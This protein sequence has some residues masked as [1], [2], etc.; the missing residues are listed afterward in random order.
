MKMRSRLT[1]CAAAVLL[2]VSSARGQLSIT[3]LNTAT[4]INFDSTVSGV[5]NGAF[6][7]SGFQSTPIAGQLD[8]DAWE[9]DGVASGQSLAFG[10]TQTTA[11]NFARA[12]STGSVGNTLGGIYAFNTSTTTTANLSLGVKPDTN[13]F[14]PGDIVLRILNSASS[15]F[16]QLALSY[17][18]FVR[19]DQTGSFTDRISSSSTNNSDYA[20]IPSLD[21]VS[22]GTS[23]GSAW[24]KISR[25]TTFTGINIAPGAFFY[26]RW[27]IFSSASGNGDELGLDDISITAHSAPEPALLLPSILMGMSWLGGRHRRLSN[28]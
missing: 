15:A 7:G 2:F 4:V 5:E 6:A 3:S 23:T 21:V 14:E 20:A 16:D 1:L 28:S 27:N 25:S 19:N 12:T 26:L 9:L 24:S 11:G 13:D 18:I 17:N 8:S 10:G 22:G